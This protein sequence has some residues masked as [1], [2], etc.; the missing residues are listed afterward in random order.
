MA[1]THLGHLGFP[2]EVNVF[3]TRRV[4]EVYQMTEDDA[5]AQGDGENFQFRIGPIGL[6]VRGDDLA[7]NQP[8]N[9]VSPQV[10]RH[11]RDD[12]AGLGL[13]E[14]IHVGH[15]FRSI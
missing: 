5:V 1:D 15:P 12:T 10:V 9:T 8:G 3:K 14:D 2:V 7:L 11:R 13:R 4:Q 6:V